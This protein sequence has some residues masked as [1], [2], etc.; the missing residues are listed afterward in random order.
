MR[1]RSASCARASSSTTKTVMVPPC[2]REVARGPRRRRR[3]H[4]AAS[5]PT[6]ARAIR[7]PRR[8]AELGSRGYEQSSL[9]PVH[10][11]R[12]AS[13]PN[14][15]PTSMI[16]SRQLRRAHATQIIAHRGG[17]RSQGSTGRR[18]RGSL[19]EGGAISV[20]ASGVEFKRLCRGARWASRRTVLVLVRETPSFTEIPD[21]VVPLVRLCARQATAMIITSA[22]E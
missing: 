12:K 1:A 9:P 16:G 13:C 18:P 17:P 3:E 4:R 22:A 14:A 8:S 20:F 5:A 6:S 15:T 10:G 7:H 11:K 2:I 21:S 19:L